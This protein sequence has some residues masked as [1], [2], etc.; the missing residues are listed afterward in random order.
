MDHASTGDRD[1]A[2]RASMARGR[3]GHLAINLGGCTL[4]RSSGSNGPRSACAIPGCAWAA[5]A[6]GTP[7]QINPERDADLVRL[8]YPEVRKGSIIDLSADNRVRELL[9]DREAA[10]EIIKTAEAQK[11][12]AETELLD[13]IA[14]HEVALVPGWRVRLQTIKRKEFIQRATSYSRLYVTRDEAA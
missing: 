7:P 6:A 5:I 8:M 4:S 11:K 1:D 9:E 14:D 12:A 13:K 2:G 10:A 3:A